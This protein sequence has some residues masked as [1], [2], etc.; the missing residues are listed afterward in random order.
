MSHTTLAMSYN[1]VYRKGIFGGGAAGQN[2]KNV[3]TTAIIA[4]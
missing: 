2:A 3:G 4:S 1:L